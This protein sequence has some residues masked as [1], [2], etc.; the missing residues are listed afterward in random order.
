M[1]NQEKINETDILC[2]SDRMVK[3]DQYVGLDNRM[4]YIL[5]KF[6][7]NPEAVLR[8]GER[9]KDNKAM[10]DRIEKII[11]TSIDSLM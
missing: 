10:I 11:G 5:D 3:E 9:I 8:I 2:L 6:K 4:Q 1:W 7:G